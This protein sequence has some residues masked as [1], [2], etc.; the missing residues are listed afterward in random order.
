MDA[1]DRAP[2]TLTLGLK[3]MTINILNR[4]IIIFLLLS[5]TSCTL[6][7]KKLCDSSQQNYVQETIYLG[8]NKPNGKVT[9]KE[10]SIF[11]DTIVTPRFPDG[12]T[13]STESGQWKGCDGKII[14]EDSHSL[15]IVH[16]GSKKEYNS[17]KEIVD[18]YKEK[19][20]QEAV[21]RVTNDVCVSF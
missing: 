18:I 12:L 8:T 14:K 16:L 7:N 5:A 13:H 21:L 10:W 3:K 9:E 1:S 6:T 11:I 20:R 2:V 4:L 15:I 19:Y 17:I